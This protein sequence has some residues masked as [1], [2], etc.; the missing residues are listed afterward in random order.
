MKAYAVEVRERVLAGIE[1]GLS[2]REVAHREGVG[3]RTV[4][5]YLKLWR[6][7]GSVAPR[8]RGPRQV[9]QAVDLAVLRQLR[10]EDPTASKQVLANRLA[11]RQGIRVSS[12]TIG[13][14]LASMGFAYKRRAHAPHVA[15]SSR[16]PAKPYGLAPASAP[17]TSP[18]RRTYP[19]DLNDAEWEILEPL[20]PKCKTGGRP[21]EWPRRELLNAMLY[22]LRNGNAWR[23]LPHDFPPWSTVYG[24]F[25]KWRISG[26]WQQVN[27]KLRSRA[28][29]RA[30]RGLSPTA[31]VMDSQSAHTTEKG[32]L[33]AGM[34]T[35]A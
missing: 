1:G 28:R 14:R 30:G 26:L 11:E 8:S 10:A 13:R 4:N 6:S 24:Y 7:T 2:H 32:G 33:M 29:W 9:L 12:G 3:L 17:P 27:D 5:Q 15:R 20:I 18:G 16:R 21:E 19:T 22:V 35:S 31:A 34:A 25:R 23:A